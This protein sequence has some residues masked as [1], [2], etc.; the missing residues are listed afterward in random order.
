MMT[1]RLTEE[2]HYALSIYKEAIQ[3]M[4]DWGKWCEIDGRMYWCIQSE[5][6]DEVD[7]LLE[8]VE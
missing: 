2:E 8:E 7:K 1:N 4:F 5:V 3:L 6:A